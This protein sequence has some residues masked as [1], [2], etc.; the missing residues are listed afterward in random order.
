ML[1][2]I[3]EDE[4]MDSEADARDYDAMD[5][6]AVNQQF[7]SDF[8]AWGHPSGEVIDVGTGPGRIPVELCRRCP[9]LNIVAV[10]LAE[11]MLALAQ[12]HIAAAGWTDRIRLVKADAKQLPF[13]DQ[14]FAAAICNGSVHHIPDPRACLRELHRVCGI[15]GTIFVRDLIRPRSERELDHLVKH[16]A[17]EANDHQRAL[18]AASLRAALTV[19]EVRAAVESLGYGPETVQQ[20]S[21][22]H[23]TWAATR[24]PLW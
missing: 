2:R 11:H 22:R 4:V 13:G 9:Q 20:T 7:V 8:L 6:T 5:F 23:W 14:A 1:P 21:D 17:A 24:R 12:Q 3:L 16:Y 19:E 18:F 15:G 10:D